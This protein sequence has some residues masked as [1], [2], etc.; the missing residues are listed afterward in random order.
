MNK[1]LNDKNFKNELKTKVRQQGKGA[2]GYLTLTNAAKA[3]VLTGVITFGFA[4]LAMAD[5]FQTGKITTN[6]ITPVYTMVKDHVGKIALAAGAFSTYLARGQ[7]FYQKS[8]AFGI[9]SVVT[10]GAIKVGT[11]MLV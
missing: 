2:A 8:M 3:A 5:W 10:A 4:E 1:N 7:D 6:L 9:G 11:T